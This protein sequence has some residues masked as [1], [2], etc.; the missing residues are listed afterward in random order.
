MHTNRTLDDAVNEQDGTPN[1]NKEFKSRQKCRK[2]CPADIYESR[3][4]SISSSITFFTPSGDTSKSYQKQSTKVSSRFR[5]SATAA[6]T[7]FNC[8]LERSYA[9]KLKRFQINAFGPKRDSNGQKI[10]RRYE[11]TRAHLCYFGT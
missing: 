4:C 5:A 9:Q 11:S 10:S 3:S 2:S 8:N 7:N 1:S 6:S